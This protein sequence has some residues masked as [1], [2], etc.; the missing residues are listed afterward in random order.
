MLDINQARGQR[1]SGARAPGR[2]VPAGSGGGSGGRRRAAAAARGDPVADWAARL[3]GAPCRPGKAATGPKLFG[4]QPSRAAQPPCGGPRPR[5][6]VCL[7]VQHAPNAAGRPPLRREG[8][9]HRSARAHLWLC[10]RAP[11]QP[12]AVCGRVRNPARANEQPARRRCRRCALKAGL[13][14][15]HPALGPLLYSRFA[16]SI[17]GFLACAQP[18]LDPQ[19]LPLGRSMKL[20]LP[21]V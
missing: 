21:T 14:P 11:Q 19:L 7:G 12:R 8:P 18:R 5:F 4:G 9:A 10:S 6:V 17:A 15:S 3:A 16:S 2:R 20:S 13:M 1:R